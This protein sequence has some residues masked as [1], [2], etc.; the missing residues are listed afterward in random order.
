[1][2]EFIGQVG[3][4]LAL[5]LLGFFAGRLAERNHY[6]SIHKR[7]DE[8]LSQPAATT[9]TIEEGREVQSAELA[10]GSVVVSVD[11]YKRFLS[12]FRMLF[13]GELRS[14]ASVLDRGKREAILRM[15]ESSP[16]A[17]VYLNFRM[18]T[19]TISKG[20]RKAIGSVE[21]VAYSTAIKFK[22]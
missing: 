19:A 8:F 10:V 11:Y 2:W 18:E 3:V 1:M 9:R 12:A 5:I 4:P 20:K 17:D 6:T 13:G 15:K 22:A 7:E 21:I 16:T 14:Y